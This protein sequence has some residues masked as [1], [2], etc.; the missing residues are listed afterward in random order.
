MGTNNFSY[1]NVLIVAPDF[2]FDNRCLDEECPHFEEDWAELGSEPTCSHVDTYYDF[3]EESYRM[4]KGDI[5]EGLNNLAKEID[6]LKTYNNVYYT[7]LDSFDKERDYCGHELFKFVISDKENNTYKEI[8]IVVRDGYYTGANLDYEIEDVLDWYINPLSKSEEARLDKQ[9][10]VLCKK[11][12]KVLKTFG[13]EY[14]KVGQFSNG[15]ALYQ[16]K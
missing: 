8:K 9:V 5:K 15:E 14:L 6:K 3:D 13:E 7:E 2:R 12:E 11:I 16:K 4:W 10:E 1:K